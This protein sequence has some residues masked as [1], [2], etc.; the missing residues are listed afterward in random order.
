VWGNFSSTDENE[1]LEKL[2]H[3]KHA[4]DKKARTTKFKQKKPEKTKTEKK[5][6]E[7]ESRRA[8][9]ARKI[10]C[11]KIRAGGQMN[12]QRSDLKPIVFSSS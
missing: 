5:T 9:R 3:A 8:G 10:G 7:P 12:G 6:T 1:T 4:T 11:A 2:T